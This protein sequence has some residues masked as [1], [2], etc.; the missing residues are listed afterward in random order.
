MDIS[1]E[2]RS[3]RPAASEEASNMFLY[4]DLHGSFIFFFFSFGW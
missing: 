3:D 2:E 4:I 1:A